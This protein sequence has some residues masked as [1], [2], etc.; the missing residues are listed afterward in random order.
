MLLLSKLITSA[1][2]QEASRSHSVLT[3]VSDPTASNRRTIAITT[4][5]LTKHD[6]DDDDGA[7]PKKGRRG[8]V[9]TVL[10]NLIF[11]GVRIDAKN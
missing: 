11:P 3:V 4:V 9:A 5:K 2:K 10:E 6:D 7:K 1:S 8:K